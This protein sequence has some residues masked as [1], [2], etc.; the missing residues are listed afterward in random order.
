MELAYTIT[1]EGESR[2]TV[3]D[4]VYSEAEA[5]QAAPRANAIEA[6]TRGASGPT[7][8]VRGTSTLWFAVSDDYIPDVAAPPFAP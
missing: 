5:K 1:A 6:S 2:T 4:T 7:Y 8:P 3:L